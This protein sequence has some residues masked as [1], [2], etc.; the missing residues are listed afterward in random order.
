MSM[1]NPSQPAVVQEVPFGGYRVTLRFKD[2]FFDNRG[3]TGSPED[4]LEDLYATPPGGGSPIAVGTCSVTFQYASAFR[5]YLIVYTLLPSDGHYFIN[6]FEDMPPSY[7]SQPD[8]P[9][10]ISVPTIIT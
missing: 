5:R 10:L 1:I 6:K 4:I 2:W 9:E 3:G 7:W 8:A